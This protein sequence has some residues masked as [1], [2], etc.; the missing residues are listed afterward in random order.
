MTVKRLKEMAKLKGRHSSITVELHLNED[1]SV[2]YTRVTHTRCEVKVN[3]PGW[4]ESRLLDFLVRHSGLIFHKPKSALA[5]E[6][7]SAAV[8]PRSDV[9]TLVPEIQPLQQPLSPSE[10]LHSTETWGD[11]PSSPEPKTHA[12]DQ[13]RI[14]ELRMTP[15]SILKYPLTAC[16]QVTDFH[17]R[18]VMDFLKWKD[19][20]TFR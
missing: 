18:F 1:G 11:V 4:E 20:R 8:W 14:C 13:L 10:P 19:C 3:W 9:N 6:C 16:M 12:D 7:L 2:Q 15:R 5:V 17:C